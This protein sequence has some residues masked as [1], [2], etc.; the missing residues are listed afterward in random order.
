MFL[1]FNLELK[2]DL[3]IGLTLSTPSL[4]NGYTHVTISLGVR[5][6]SKCGPRSK[7][8][9]RTIFQVINR[10]GLFGLNLTD[11]KS[12]KLKSLNLFE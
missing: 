6:V 2:P 1:L 5:D 8:L 4:V 7:V 9:P 11:L 10:K 3:G 12:F